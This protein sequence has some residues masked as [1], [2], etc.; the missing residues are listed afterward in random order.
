MSMLAL[1]PGWDSVCQCFRHQ[2]M[3]LPLSVL[4]TLEGITC[5][6]LLVWIN[7]EFFWQFVSSPSFI[8]PFH[9]LFMPVWTHSSLFSTLSSN[10]LLLYLAQTVPAL[11]LSGWLLCSLDELLSILFWSCC[12][13]CCCCVASVVSDSVR[14]HRWQPTRLLCPWDSPCKNTGVGCHFLLQLFWSTSLQLGTIRCSRLTL[15][16]YCLRHRVSSLSNHPWFF[17]LK[18]DVI[19]LDPGGIQGSLTICPLSWQSKKMYVS[20]LTCW[21]PALVDPG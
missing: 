14:P 18:N 5:A 13:C 3:F 1:T 20:K 4:H 16:I 19:N 8:K 21:G 10:P 11:A 9:H 2:V 17:S 12:C 7:L 15:D 6:V